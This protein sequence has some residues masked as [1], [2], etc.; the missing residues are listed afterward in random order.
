MVAARPGLDGCQGEEAGHVEG[1]VQGPRAPGHEHGEIENG[2]WQHRRR[3]PQDVQG[4][5]RPGRW[6]SEAGVSAGPR[7]RAAY[8]TGGGRRPRARGSVRRLLMMFVCAC[9]A[10]RLLLTLIFTCMTRRG[11]SAESQI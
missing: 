10:R 4:D 7:P 3:L 5:P 8:A 6:G 11:A 2:S 9:M 1:G